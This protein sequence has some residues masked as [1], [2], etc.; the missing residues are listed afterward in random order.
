M[1]STTGVYAAALVAA[2]VLFAPIANAQT[3]PSAAPSVTTP[4]PSSADIPDKK[5]DAAAAAAKRVTAV[6]D[7]YEQKMAQAPA[8]EKQR[9]VGEANDATIKAVTDQGLSLD[10]Y[11]NIMKT[12]QVDPAVRDKLIQRL[13]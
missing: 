13:K 1:K 12:A 6:R 8:A 10:E 2:G 11:T 4:S 3:P 7:N 9:L 5:L